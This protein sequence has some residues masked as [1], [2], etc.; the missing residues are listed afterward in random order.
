M[1]MNNKNKKQEQ[2]KPLKVNMEFDEMMQRISRVDK[3]Q[4]EKNIKRHEKKSN[5]R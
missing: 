2:D 4:V 5:D 3:N 1:E